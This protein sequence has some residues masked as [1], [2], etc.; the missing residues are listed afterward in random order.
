MI[1]VCESEVL[2]YQLHLYTRR[3]YPDVGFHEPSL[4]AT[5]SRANITRMRQL[6][7]LGDVERAALAAQVLQALPAQ[8]LPAAQLPRTA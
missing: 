3:L 8:W 2:L 1:C 4:R 6:F 5:L 7:D